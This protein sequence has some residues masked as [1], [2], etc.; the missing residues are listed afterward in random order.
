[1]LGRQLR[2]WILGGGSGPRENDG[3]AIDGE[4]RMS[5]DQDASTFSLP[6]QL[7]PG[8]RQEH[9]LHGQTTVFGRR[10]VVTL[11][12]SSVNVPIDVG[13]ALERPLDLPPSRGRRSS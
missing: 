7:A 6:V 2:R 9:L 10:F 5:A 13:A 8:A 3:P 11:E 4:L 1:M 12:S